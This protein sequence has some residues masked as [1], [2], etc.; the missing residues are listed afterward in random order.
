MKVY[1]SCSCGKKIKK[2][3][4]QKKLVKAAKSLKFRLPAK[5]S[6]CPRGRNSA[7]SMREKGLKRK[8]SFKS[9]GATNNHLHL[10]HV[11]KR[12]LKEKGADF[13]FV[14]S[15]CPANSNSFP[16]SWAV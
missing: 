8:L 10:N 6:M 7:L 13:T 2:F 11:A 12:W 16:F 5:E 14:F 3:K 15:C 9:N 4:K 1:L